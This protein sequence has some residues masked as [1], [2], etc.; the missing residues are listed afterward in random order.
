MWCIGLTLSLPS[1]LSSTRLLMQA[2][3]HAHLNYWASDRYQFSSISFIIFSHYYPQKVYLQGYYWM[4]TIAGNQPSYVPWR[5]LNIDNLTTLQEDV[6]RTIDNFK[7]HVKE[8]PS[9]SKEVIDAKDDVERRMAV[10]FA[11]K[12]QHHTGIY[13]IKTYFK[14]NNDFLY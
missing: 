5:P 12:K 7:R 6:D 8:R 4:G 2:R 9:S 3:K 10:L 13:T 1:S 14:R 11:F